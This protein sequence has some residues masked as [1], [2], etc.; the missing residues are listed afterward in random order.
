MLVAVA[1]ASGVAIF[2]LAGAMGLTGSWSWSMLVAAGSAGLAGWVAWRHPIVPLDMRACSRPLAIV[3]GVATIAALF[4]LARLCAFIID[5]SQVGCAMGPTRGLGLPIAHSCVSAYYVAGQA[6]GRVPNVYEDSLYNL[7]REQAV[8]PRRPRPI[9]TFNID[10]YEYPP[11]FLL[12]PRALIAVAPEFLRHRMIWFALEGLVMLAALLAAARFLGPVAGTRALLLSPLVWA[13]EMTIGTLQVGN[14][15]P[16]VIALAVLAMLLIERRRDAAGG[17]LL[18]FITVSKLFPGLLLIYLIV[19]R[20][21]RALAWTA[22]V[23]IALVLV[24]LLDTGWEPYRAFVHHLPGLLS[25]EAFPAFRNPNAIAKNYSVPGMVFKLGLF[26]VPG[27]AFGAAKIVGWIYTLVAVAVTVV[28]ARRTLDREQQVLAWLAILILATLRSPFLPGY[29]VWPPLWLLTILAARTTPTARTMGVV[30]LAWVGLNVAV[31]QAGLDPRLA[32]L[33]ILIPQ[34]VIVALT[35]LAL[36][37]PQERA[38][39][40]KAA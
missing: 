21:W 22:G 24:S 1:L 40:A 34:A 4:Q 25:G 6:V 3:S 18:A 26:G 2:T 30:L 32:T 27:M 9:G 19:R 35:V 7:P 12:L 33:I 10:V 36:R 16:V 28:V 17:A 5:P 23:S 31:P 20:R 29:A 14:I 38:A 37:A 39:V 13:A 8:G 11:P 15:Q